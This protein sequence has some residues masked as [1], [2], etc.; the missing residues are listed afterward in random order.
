MRFWCDDPIGAARECTQ[1]YRSWCDQEIEV[2][3]L[4][5]EQTFVFI[6]HYEME[7]C[8]TAVYF[9]GIIE[10]DRPPF[11]DPEWVFALARHTFLKHL[12]H[13]WAIS[14]NGRYRAGWV[15]LAHQWLAH[16]PLTAESATGP[17]RSL[18]SAIRVEHWLR[19]IEI[20]ERGGDPLPASLL[21]EL[22]ASLRLHQQ[23][24]LQEHTAFHRISNWGII[25]DHGL[26]LI[27]SYFDDG[28][29][30]EVALSRLDEEL[31][32]QTCPDGSH[33]EQSPL[34]QAEV[35]HCVLD[36]IL[37][38]QRQG[39]ELGARFL[40]NARLLA[41]GLGKLSRPDGILFL[42]GDS[43]AID[44][45]DL[46]VTA[47]I[48]F[49]DRILA[50]FGQGARHPSFFFNFP[51]DQALV[52]PQ[53]PDKRFYPFVHSGNYLM[54]TTFES[55]SGCVRF[56]CGPYSSGHGHFDQLHVDL[57]VNGQPILTDGGRFT[58]VDSIGRRALKSGFAHN[59]IIVDG[60]DMSE[61]V[62]SW[63][64]NHIAEPLAGR[65]YSSE[66]IDYVEASHLG[67]LQGGV[68]VRR[69]VLRI[70]EDL[71]I[72][73]DECYATGEHTYQNFF[74]FDDLGR[75]TQG[76]GQQV[77][78]TSPSAHATMAFIGADSVA[79][80]RYPLSKRYNE[81]SEGDRAV[82]TRECTGFA[83]LITVI[84]YGKTPKSLAVA[85][86]EVTKSLTGTAVDDRHATGLSIEVDGRLHTVLFIHQEI[87]KGG[88]LL[89]CAE[90]EGWGRVLVRTEGEETAAVMW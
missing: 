63:A 33:W 11:G 4:A 36:T 22:E 59:T 77:V 86:E 51:I 9:D 15:A 45:T 35:L 68:L 13:A 7:R 39:R 25:Q 55:D 87:D 58:Y 20:F 3:D 84:A 74:H 40:Q 48:L 26:F 83:R 81:M 43:D 75:A 66:A 70:E 46:F 27:G 61:M 30:I 67:Y 12:A 50:F 54:R 57:M 17:W 62:D 32:L 31:S 78:F 28:H 76:S 16:V 34:Y 89:R 90:A 41:Q 19:S 52:E 18:D 47:S 37:I 82:L 56:H 10:W 42:Q 5:L 88:Y 79:M 53:R 72:L 44:V 21:S 38:A 49:D 64:V 29:T 85:T 8:T 71:L 60:S 65:H 1:L 80:D 6:D 73:C 2:A 24:L 14:G 23:H 69:K